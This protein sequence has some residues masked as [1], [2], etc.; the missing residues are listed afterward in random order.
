MAFTLNDLDYYVCETTDSSSSATREGDDRV[1]QK[2][3]TSYRVT[4]NGL[5]DTYTGSE[6]LT[7][8]SVPTELVISAD[9]LPKVNASTYFYGGISNPYL[10]CESKSVEREQGNR[11]SFIVTVTWTTQTVQ[12]EEKSQQQPPEQLS[13]I[14][15]TVAV[16]ITGREIPIWKDKDGSQ[17]WRMPGTGTPF[18]EPIVETVP[19]FT[20]TI[21]QFEPSITYLQMLERSYKVNSDDYRGY[22]PHHWMTGPVSATNARVRLASGYVDV[23]KVVYTLELADNKAICAVTGEPSGFTQGDTISYGHYQTVPLVDDHALLKVP[24]SSDVRL[25]PIHRYDGAG[26]PITDDIT[27]GYIYN[28]SNGVVEPGMLRT[29]NVAYLNGPAEGPP[30]EGLDQPS[31]MFFRSQKEISFSFLQA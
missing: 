22:G 25:G 17:C 11:L 23:A 7:A 10:V 1:T 2:A 28:K 8:S 31:Y 9:E 3:S 27:T 24:G 29:P 30:K 19:I 15:P 14:E 18:V 12:G 21:T 20:F 16:K 26:D 13:D 5:S 6:E 4:V